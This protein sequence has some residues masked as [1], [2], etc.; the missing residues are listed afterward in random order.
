MINGIDKWQWKKNSEKK[1]VKLITK[2]NKD[3]KPA[4]RSS[5][6]S[7]SDDTKNFE[8]SF[9]SGNA[10]VSEDIDNDIVKSWSSKKR[11]ASFLQNDKLKR[12]KIC[13]DNNIIIMNNKI[14]KNICITPL[15]KESRTNDLNEPY[16][17][18]SRNKNNMTEEF[19]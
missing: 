7:E 5:S 9:N 19:C 16:D 2:H 11:K 4:Y 6:L 8:N 14:D 12:N 3:T 15:S 1:V 17:S 10:D 18:Q 13:D